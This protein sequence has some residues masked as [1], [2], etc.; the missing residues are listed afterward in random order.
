M[1]HKPA[2]A[3]LKET[4][5]PGD[6]VLGLFQDL[7]KECVENDILSLGTVVEFLQDDDVFEEGTY[8]PEIHFIVRKVEND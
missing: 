5:V 8:I 1:L 6:R 2:I 3:R 7:V 4:G